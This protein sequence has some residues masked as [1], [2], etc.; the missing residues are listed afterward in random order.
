M[1]DLEKLEKRIRSLEAT[2][3]LLISLKIDLG[4][5]AQATLLGMLQGKD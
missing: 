3:G 5:S 2:L 4:E 1:T